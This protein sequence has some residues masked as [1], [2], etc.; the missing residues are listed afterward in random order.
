M[1]IRPDDP[2]G[3]MKFKDRYYGGRA[4]IVLGGPSGADWRKIRDEIK[5]DVIL[6]A[7]GNLD[8]GAEFWMLAE[9]MN[10]QYRMMVDGKTEQIRARGRDFMRL[11]EQENTARVKLISCLSWNLLDLYGIDKSNCVCVRR[12]CEVTIDHFPDKFSLREYGDGFLNGPVIQHIEGV[13]KSVRFNVGTV[14]V[15]LLHFAGILGCAEAHTIG[16]DF[17]F[18]GSKHHWYPHPRYMEDR[19]RTEKMF[20]Q[21]N[22]IP[23]LWE[24]VEGAEW[25]KSI[26]SIFKRDGLK[27]TDHSKGLFQSMGLECAS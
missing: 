14:G 6:A 26:E 15:H 17:C 1:A 24:W 27:W 2:A 11:L 21:Y 4:L 9:N 7:N 16:M 13:Q 5:P 20:T 3:V 18:K 8:V 22:G 19:F 10:Y 23:T 25:L 12:L